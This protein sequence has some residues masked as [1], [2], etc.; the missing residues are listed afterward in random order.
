M[1]SSSKTIDLT[2]R[3][4]VR[5]STSGVLSIDAQCLRSGDRESMGG[6]ADS[7]NPDDLFTLGEHRP[8]VPPASWH[9][10]LLKAT[11]HQPPPGAAER[12]YPLPFGPGANK[13]R[14][15]G[16]PRCS[17]GALLP[18]RD[19]AAAPTETPAPPATLPPLALELP[20]GCR[21]LSRGDSTEMEPAEGK[22]C[23][24]VAPK[25]DTSTARPAL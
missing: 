7:G 2:G 17:G 6:A 20:R 21:G 3:P 8:R 4:P 11:H 22:V 18:L 14:V 23:R 13:Q 12:L 19:T 15:E 24:P 10:Q 1:V 5:R 25:G 9:P 16:E